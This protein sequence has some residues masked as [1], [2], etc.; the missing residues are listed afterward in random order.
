MA[1]NGSILRTR[2]LLGRAGWASIT[3][4]LFRRE[5][6][7]VDAQSFVL[8]RDQTRTMPS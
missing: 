4:A 5:Y 1:S 8:S 6:D 3:N 2:L 7:S